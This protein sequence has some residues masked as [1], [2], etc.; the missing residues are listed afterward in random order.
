MNDKYTKSPAARMTRNFFSQKV[1]GRQVTRA[2]NSIRQKN[3]GETPPSQ[4]N[5]GLP[6]TGRQIVT[7]VTGDVKNL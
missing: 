6:E 4:Q 7:N 3:S 1:P 2:F 5:H